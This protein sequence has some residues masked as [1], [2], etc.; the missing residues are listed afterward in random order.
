MQVLIQHQN[1]RLGIH[2]SLVLSKGLSNE[3]I[4]DFQYDIMPLCMMQ[5]F[6]PIKKLATL[7]SLTSLWKRAESHWRYSKHLL[8]RISREIKINSSYQVFDLKEFSILSV[9]LH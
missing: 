3:H 4:P 1:N 2:L 9:F 8:A 5:T 6:Q 7:L